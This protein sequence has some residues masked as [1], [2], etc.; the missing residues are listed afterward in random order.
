V[1]RG[2]GVLVG[3]G[4]EV[5]EGVGVIVGVKVGG[6]V[7]VTV[8]VGV[9]VQVGGTTGPVGVDVAVG[10]VSRATRSAGGKGL[11]DVVGLRR[12]KM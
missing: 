10:K 5:G 9:G 3:L 1:T 8:G 11:R 12:M 6:G 7:G 4:V 2:V